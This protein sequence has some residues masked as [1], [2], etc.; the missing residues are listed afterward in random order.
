VKTVVKQLRVGRPYFSEKD[1]DEIVHQIGTVLHS[2]WLTSGKVVADFELRFS[3]AV[4]AKYAVATNSCTAALHMLMKILDLGPGNEVILP[5]NTFAS[6]ANAVLYVGAR[7]VFA[8]CD[9]DTFN[10]TAESIRSSIT[11]KTKAVIVVHVAGNPC[12]MQEI[13]TLCSREGLILVED[14]AHAH[15]SSYRGV[16]CGTFGLAGAFSFYPTKVIT[17]GEGGMIA[18]PSESIYQKA[19]TLRNVGRAEV[20]CGP[21]TMLGYNYRMTDVHACIGLNQLRHLDEFVRKRNAL[22]RT[23]AENLKQIGWIRPQQVAADSRCSYYA[24]I[25]RLL[26]GAPTTRDSL[27][28]RLKSKGIETTIMYEPVYQ[29]PYYPEKNRAGICPNAENVGANGIVLPLH[30]EMNPDDVASVTEAIGEINP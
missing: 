13:A 10:V 20:G 17:S 11:P 2:G 27:I 29:H 16:N 9:I 1:I 3:E 14:C 26:P 6:T 8:D 5:A 12:E 28:Q 4:G 15:G 7:P 19:R 24:Y 30:V 23:Y 22:A 18:T 25:C 21:V